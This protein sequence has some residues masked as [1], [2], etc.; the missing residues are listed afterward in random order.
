MSGGDTTAGDD[1]GVAAHD[2]ATTNMDTRAE[3]PAIMQTLD[4][5]A[6]AYPLAVEKR[7]AIY[8]RIDRIGTNVERGAALLLDPDTT[9][10]MDKKA[11]T[12]RG[13]PS[14]VYV[15]QCGGTK[16]QLNKAEYEEAKDMAKA[17]ARAPKPI[18][19]QEFETLAAMAIP[20]LMHR[21]ILLAH[22][23]T[24]IKDVLAVTKELSDR[25]FGKAK[26]T[27]D[28]THSD[29]DIRKAWDEFDNYV[30]PV[31]LEQGGYVAEADVADSDNVAGGYVLDLEDEDAE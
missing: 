27:V 16:V 6:G 10:Q 23:S 12:G 31:A 17:Q 3:Q 25:A 8:E 22:E 2:I 26:Q 13:R 15:L 11:T 7:D 28:I 20:Q 21:A 4:T 30:G 24:S 29:R 14:S 9:V 18:T 1:I 5:I 19:Q